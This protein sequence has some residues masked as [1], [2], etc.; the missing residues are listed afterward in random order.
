MSSKMLETASTA[1]GVLISVD[2]VEGLMVTVV[3]H[4][5]YMVLKTSVEQSLVELFVKEKSS[6]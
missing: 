6:K 5:E 4:F 1:V 3:G 2:G